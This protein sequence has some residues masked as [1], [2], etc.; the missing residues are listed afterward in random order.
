MEAP[1]PDVVEPML[2]LTE[3]DKSLEVS[4]STEPVLASLNQGPNE[5]HAHC[6]WL[7]DIQYFSRK[8][9]P[10]TYLLDQDWNAFAVTLAPSD[11]SKVPHIYQLQLTVPRGALVVIKR[12]RRQPLGLSYRIKASRV[13]INRI[14]RLDV[15]PKTSSVRVA[16]EVQHLGEFQAG[17]TM[18][19]SPKNNL[20]ILPSRS[21]MTKLIIQMN[22]A[23]LSAARLFFTNN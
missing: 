4:T 18:D 1:V 13:C 5:S 17:R 23:T 14:Y 19:L 20:H 10:G 8:R 15:N 6:I 11:T 22:Q 7:R 12:Q 16:E 2:T 9:I 3:E 21:E